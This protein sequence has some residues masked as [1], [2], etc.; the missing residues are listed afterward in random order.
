MT[1]TGITHL[2]RGKW[3]QAIEALEE[4]LRLAG[5]FWAA[6][7][8]GYLILA[9]AF[10]GNRDEA[11][12][13]LQGVGDALPRPG[14][15]NLLGAWNL[16]ILLA[17]AVGLLGLEGWAKHLYPLVT[18]A[19]ATGAIMRQ[20]DGRLIQTSAGMV[21]AAAGLPDAADEH[22]TVALAQADQL[23]HLLERP[24]VRHFYGRFL[25]AQGGAGE[26]ARAG[27]L[28]G[29]AVDGYR[30]LGMARHSALAR[31]LLRTA[32]TDL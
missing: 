25:D 32:Q 18:E 2:W 3:P 14:Q 9:Q 28:L 5:A 24:F 31:E 17:E 29:E 20:L 4:G 7:Q 12:K 13:R 10:C 16:A 8:L 11:L 30:A 19:L 22:F 1:L 21:A 15:A 26:K 23:P 6:P 27:S